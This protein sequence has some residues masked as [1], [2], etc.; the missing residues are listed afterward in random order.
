MFGNLNKPAFG[1]STPSTSFGFGAS[2]PN[3]T[4]PFGQNQI[5]GKP[6]GGFGSP[7]TSAF[8][9]P[10]NSLFPS[11]QPQS[12]GLFQNANTGFGTAV[13]TQSGFGTTNLF[14]Q[15]QQQQPT[16]GVLF[17]TT[18]TFGQQNKPTG[19]GFGT[20]ATQPGLFGQ[21]QQQQQQPTSLFQPA[22]NNL[23]GASNAFGQQSTG[24]GTVKF[25]PV[26]GTDTMLKNG[27]ATSI[28]TKHHSITCMKEYENKSFEE[29]RFEDYAA[30]RKGPQN[31]LFSGPQQQTGFGTTPFGGAS[32][33]PTMFGQTDASKTGF[34]G[35]GQQSTP[36][37]GQNTGFGQ[38]QSSSLFGKPATGFGTT[39][40]QS[41]LGFGFNNNNTQAGIMSF[42]ANQQPKAFGTS[43]PSIFGANTATTQ[44]TG[45][46]G[47]GLFGQTNT[48]NT[49]VSL[50]GKPAQPAQP[51]FGTSQNN[52]FSFSTTTSTQASSLFQPA[53]PLFGQSTTTP[54]FGQTN[55]FGTGGF[56]NTFGKPVAPAFGATTTPAFGT[57]LG[58]GLQPQ[59]TSLFGNTAAKPGGLFTN[60]SATGLFNNTNTSFQPNTGF[61]L[62]QTQPAQQSMFPSGDQQLSTNLALLTADPFGDAPHLA[63]LEPKLKNNSPNVSVT[64]PKELK[65]LLDGYKT[66][67]DT[68]IS[69]PKIIPIR[70]TRDNLFDSVSPTLHSDNNSK[71]YVKTNCRRLILKNRTSSGAS[72]QSPGIMKMDILKQIMNS[73]TNDENLNPVTNTSDLNVQSEIKKSPL[74]LSF[75]NTLNEDSAT[76]AGSFNSQPSYCIDNSL[77]NKHSIS[78]EKNPKKSTVDAEVE[79]DINDLNAMGD[80]LSR[81][82]C[83]IICTRP[84]YYTLPSLDELANY[85]EEPGR[86]IVK[87]FTIGRKGYGNVYFPD[88]MDVYGLNIDELVHF[89]YREINVY[90]DDEKKPPV[91]QG[92]NRKAQVTLDNVY[93]KQSNSHALVTDVNELLKINFAEKLRRITMNKNAKFVDYRPETGS[94][95]FKVEHFSKYGFDDNDE[96]TVQKTGQDGGGDKKL[97]TTKKADV[98]LQAK[99]TTDKPAEKEAVTQSLTKE[100]ETYGIDDEIFMEDDTRYRAEA[101]VLRTSMF[102]D[103]SDD[104]YNLP[105]ELPLHHHDY[106]TSKNIQVMKSTLFADDDRSS[107]G[108][109][110][111]ISII[112]QYLDIP[113]EIRALP[114]ITEE[115]SIRRKV[116]LRPKVEKVYNVNEKEL[117]A[118]LKQMRSYQDLALFKGKSFK[119]GWSKGFRFYNVVQ[120]QEGGT[121]LV[122]SDIRCGS[123]KKFEPK[124]EILKDSLEIVLEESTF[125]LDLNQIPT[126]KIIKNHSYLKKQMKLFEKLLKEYDNKETRYL[127]SIWTLAD[128]LWGPTENTPWNRRHL[129]SEW[130]KFNTDYESIDSNDSIKTIFDKLSIHRI[131][132][133]A[134]IALEKRHPNLALIISQ[135]SVT[136][137]TKLFLQ[138]QI[139][140]WY[141]SM[142]SQHIGD[143]TKKIYLLLAGTPIRDEVNIFE[144]IDW[145]R[146]LGMHLWYVSPVG[147]PIEM[148]IEMYK[149]AFEE[150]TYASSPNPPYRTTYEEDGSFDLLFHILMLYYSKAHRLST[151]LD[152]STHTDDYLDYWLGWLLLQL[153]TSL[154]VGIMED[155]EKVKLCTSFSNQLE[156]LGEWEWAIFVL[157]HLEDD[158]IKR[159]LVLGILDRNLSC[160]VNKST[161]KVENNL[162]NK[163][164]VPSEW[165]H[166]V[167][168]DKALSNEKYF[169]AFNHF[170]Q[171]KDYCKAN[172]ILVEHL[173]PVLFVNEQYDIIKV[174]ISE[175]EEG[176]N[177]IERWNNEAGLF[178]DF[179]ELQEKYVTS[180][181]NLRIQ[182]SLQ[183]IGNR[184]TSFVSSN[185]HQ[186]LCL[187]EMSKRC[188]AI[189]KEFCRKTHYSAFKNSYLEFIENLNMP[190]DFKQ[191]EALYAINEIK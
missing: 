19:F 55:T 1:T 157:L 148:V 168:G 84:E 153:F 18:S 106:T 140:N 120:K 129:L 51:G 98:A 141:K 146:A 80:S 52:A 102:V 23:F 132:E 165:I 118:N 111:H 37:F 131:N 40:S 30:N 127:H 139:E 159:N 2:T 96:E 16:T 117:G 191:I 113:D 174:L 134:S 7:S 97:E 152:S 169:Q 82:P 9:Q 178:R 94:W 145:K 56:G 79:T 83:H 180:D 73:P 41:N 190:P 104:D 177:D 183:S 39:T 179:I 89:R 34:T 26:T 53:K 170:A 21:T 72:G 58:G 8:G 161:I 69:K 185:N 36:A 78:I 44:S 66:A 54:A 188:C 38:Q 108:G 3:T 65:S 11:T 167:K 15:Q 99:V 74:K 182:M 17:N 110:S 60:N 160:D 49:G 46:G 50:F 27:V 12:T 143:T 144:D 156:S 91:G 126:Y 147:A 4:N 187:A 43:A 87:G 175:I 13:S 142:T 122:L 62:G 29:L 173:L 189:Y 77:I 125:T 64:N 158:S 107:D 63:G 176:S 181:D 162:V 105:S 68:H 128:A 138:E 115:V 186:K 81:H 90:P 20:Q 92:L 86:C 172:D 119:V 10:T 101:D 149:K 31:T 22:A 70:S 14:G 24:T 42:G 100:L 59:N 47:G 57:T 116:I 95:V 45:F 35:F 6:A 25:N 5:F 71:E 109:G 61:N 133:A 114:M 103:I 154:D 121:E 151:V 88:E 184:I 28:N 33:A 137:N 67:D 123:A 85:I 150:Y 93:P 75:D 124:E 32:T 164:R 130:L 48:Q 171:A 166:S 136:N 163:M 76:Q 155:S 135:L 112:R